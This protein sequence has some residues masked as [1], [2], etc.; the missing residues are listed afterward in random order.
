MSAPKARTLSVGV[1]AVMLITSTMSLRGLASQ[2]EYGL[3][4]AFYYLL[5]AVVFLIPYGMTCAE[6]ASMYPQE[7]GVYRWVGEAFGEKWGWVA[8][9]LDWV[10]IL[11][12]F[13]PV[14]MFGASC[15][16]YIFWPEGFDQT[17]ASSKLY[18][19]L[20]VLGMYWLAI[21]NTF[22]GLS[23][24]NRLST[25]GGL[26]GTI[27]PGVVLIVL[28]IIWLISGK[29]IEMN[30]HQRFLPDFSNF[31]TVVLAASI[32]L[33]YSGIEVQAPHIPALKNPAK[34]F[35]K[36]IMIAI[37]SIVLLFV[38]G[39]LAI[40][41][42]VPHKDINLLQSMLV[43]YK[44][45]WEGLGAGWMGNVM[46]V[47]LTLG[48][49][50]QSSINGTGPAL[51]LM[52]VGRAGGLPPWLQRENRHGM[53]IHLLLVQSGIITFLSLTLVLLPTVQSAYQVL[54]QLSTIVYLL[55]VIMIYAA[56][57]S[58]RRTAPNATRRF[59]IPGGKIGLGV[60]TG[61][62]VAGALLAM[63][64]SF[65]PPTQIRTGNPVLYIGILIGGLVIFLLFPFI[66]YAKRKPGWKNPKKDFFPFAWKIEG[67][68]PT[69]VSKW[70]KGY[71]PTTQE[72]EKAKKEP[73]RAFLK[74][75]CR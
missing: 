17:L 24:A 11:T 55:M 75:L 54:G 52:A 18:T 37:T 33:F 16:A 7:G 35:T 22:R 42:S 62:G 60:V 66:L 61:L 34:G 32:F 50:G 41:I 46:A 14:L 48:V 65:I 71:K 28:G 67:R 51:G 58:L 74:R 44:T 25:L 10:M 64:L 45:L 73:L 29:P 36:A 6:L 57:I 19:I 38:L 39:T 20:V 68:W 43:A 53:P 56:C 40:A 13:P 72:V 69:Q 23:S 4:S 8:I 9:Y 30:L 27:G 15:L 70:P 59:R 1:M 3:T 47:F 2:A 12:W 5:A 31:G 21:V 26:L 63:A 49:L